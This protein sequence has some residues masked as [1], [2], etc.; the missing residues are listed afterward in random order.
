MLQI[1]TNININGTIT[2]DNQPVV[3]LN[4]DTNSGTGLGANVNRSIV[5][6]DL[7]A[8]NMDLIREDIAKFEKMVYD[9]E[10]KNLVDS[11]IETTPPDDPIIDPPVEDETIV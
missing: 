7:Y 1:T 11:G 4:A 9:M 8:K 10:D 5:N 3:Y 2:I 6:Q